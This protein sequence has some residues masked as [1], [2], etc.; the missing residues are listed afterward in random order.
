MIETLEPR[1]DDAH[2]RNAELAP[3]QIDRNGLSNSCCN[4]PFNNPGDLRFDRFEL[5]V[6]NRCELARPRDG[7]DRKSVV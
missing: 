4:Q 2:D 6:F 7:L 1:R 5:K 3:R